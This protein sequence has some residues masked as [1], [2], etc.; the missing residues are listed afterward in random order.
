KP[1]PPKV[2]FEKKE[3][4]SPSEDRVR[5]SAR[6]SESAPV[7]KPHGANAPRSGKQEKTAADWI[8]VLKDTDAARRI[9][10][11]EAL[12]K[13]GAKEAVPALV[14][15]L[16]D[17]RSYVRRSAVE[18]LG[19]IGPR[20]KDAI[21]VLIPKSHDPSTEVRRE[22]VLTL[23]KIDPEAK[24]VTATFGDSLRDPDNSV[25]Q[26][27]TEVLI[28]ISISPKQTQ[29]EA[30]GILQAATTD[31][32]LQVCLRSIAALGEVGADQAIPTLT[33]AVKRKEA[34][35]RKKAVESL[36]KIGPKSKTVVPAL[37]EGLKEVDGD[38]RHFAVET[39]GSL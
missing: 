22:V 27:A 35:I 9:Q 15:I 11:A 23:A 31:R 33:A 14:A 36:G 10:A 34:T 13:I 2:G 25:S 32:N 28:Q 37:L 30:L 24:E 4:A 5:K 16:S 17:D 18:A 38:I 19:Q 39:L 12:G 8:P 1:P 21:S 26:A 6:P 20:A 7:A 29:K 3:S